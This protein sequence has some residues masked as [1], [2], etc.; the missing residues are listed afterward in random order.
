M[1]YIILLMLS[2]FLSL[3]N[4]M[5]DDQP[6]TPPAEGKALSPTQQWL[7]LQRSGKSASSHPQP[8]SGEV[9]DSVHKRYLKSFEKPIPELYERETSTTH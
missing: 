2:G 6:A 7:E 8:I 5:A 9:M 1:K 4:A 3:S